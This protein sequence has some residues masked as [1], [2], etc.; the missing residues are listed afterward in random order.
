MVRER[1]SLSVSG[2]FLESTI[3]ELVAALYVFT[4]GECGQNLPPPA[5]TRIMINR[6]TTAA[7]M[8]HLRSI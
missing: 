7:D 3:E 2:T 6:R 8:G 1:H 4:K 5:Q